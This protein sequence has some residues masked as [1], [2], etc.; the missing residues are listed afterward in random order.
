MPP[1]A[2]FFYTSSHALSSIPPFTAPSHC[3]ASAIC[4][5]CHPALFASKLAQ[6][7]KT[8]LL[9]TSAHALSSIPPLTAPSHC[10]ASAICRNCHP[11]LFASKLARCRKTILLST[12]A[13][14][15]SSIPPLR[16]SSHC[17]ASAHTHALS[18]IPPLT[19][20]SHCMA[21]AICRNCH[22]ALF[23]SKL[24]QCRKTIPA[25]ERTGIT[26][27]TNSSRFP[28]RSPAYSM[29][30]TLSSVL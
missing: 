3:M 16:A 27:C 12:S 5:N 14:A 22:P 24:A 25:H 4:R 9:S 8:I 2:V 1:P 13:H 10:M 30:Y 29:L 23:A 7:R 15:P 28:S 19:A 18:S 26:S 11:A 20:P 17:M 6:C 21:S